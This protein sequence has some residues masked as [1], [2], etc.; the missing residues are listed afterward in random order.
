[1][2][3]IRM[4][5]MHNS[6]ALQ[7]DHFRMSK[8]NLSM[9]SLVIVLIIP[10]HLLLQS[11]H[12]GCFQVNCQCMICLSV[13]IHD[14]GKKTTAKLPHYSSH[15]VLVEIL[16]PHRPYS[17]QKYQHRH[18]ALFTYLQKFLTK[19][20]FCKRNVARIS[21]RLWYSAKITKPR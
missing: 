13:G 14:S 11:S 4:R 20:V 21:F 9:L 15:N 16:F 8:R 12:F 3:S 10:L 2:S 5:S 1:M 17:N 18:V 6:V 7:R 19:E